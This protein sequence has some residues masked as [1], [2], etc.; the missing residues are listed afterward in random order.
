MTPSG[1]TN[2]DEIVPVMEIIK[3]SDPNKQYGFP[4]G[5][6]V[7]SLERKTR[8]TFPDTF[9][10]YKWPKKS[11]KKSQKKYKR[12]LKVYYNFTSLLCNNGFH[13]P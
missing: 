11:C 3:K 2:G 1:S 13:G 7:N 12:M 4:C 5:D 9:S 10:S 6:K 8:E